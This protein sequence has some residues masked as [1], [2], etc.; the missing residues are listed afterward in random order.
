M[1]SST[2]STEEQASLLIRPREPELRPHPAGQVR[3]VLAQH[4]DRPWPT[5]GKSPAT[6]LNRVRLAGAVRPED[7]AALA[8]RDI[9]IHVTHGLHPA[10][11][12]A[13]P[14]QAE[15]RLGARC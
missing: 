14:P 8:V 10:E 4:L 2:D 5:R 1:L 6:R 7:G 13:D 12:P 15:D 9:G 11:A 3:H